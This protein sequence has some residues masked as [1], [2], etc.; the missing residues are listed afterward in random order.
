MPLFILGL[1]ESLVFLPGIIDLATVPRWAILAVGL[2]LCLLMNQRVDLPASRWLGSVAL[3]FMALTSLWTPDQLTGYQ[4]LIWLCILA[5]A[6][7]LGAITDDLKPLWTGLAYGVAVSAIL[8][9]AQR[10]EFVSTFGGTNGS[11]L[12]TNKILMAEATMVCLIAMLM[13]KRWWIAG[14]LFL[15]FVAATSRGAMIGLTAALLVWL[16]AYRP[17]L[18]GTLMLVAVA[19]FGITFLY[20]NNVLHHESATLRMKM[21]DAALSGA[22]WFGNGIG[23]YA[24]TFPVWEH[25]HSD[26][27]QAIYE[28]GILC[29]PFIALMIVLLSGGR[30]DVEKFILIAVLTSGLFAFPLHMPFTAFAAAVAAGSL[31]ASWGLVRLRINEGRAYSGLFRRWESSTGRGTSPHRGRLS[32]CVPPFAAH[33]AAEGRAASAFLRGF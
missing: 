4:E 22:T 30:H 20:M 24:T 14:V 10:L 27:F 2:P 7:Y 32:G 17:K 6:F 31:T 15:G 11:G 28:C 33:E 29:I 19:A 8:A 1:L 13:Y 23:S 5:V 26:L 12:F 21:W 25:A 3:G 16:Y 18:A 9:V